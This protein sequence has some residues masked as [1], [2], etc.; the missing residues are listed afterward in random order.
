M[1]IKEL[2]SSDI[3]LRAKKHMDL[4][5]SN[6]KLQDAL[7]NFQRF[8]DENHEKSPDPI[9][10][11]PT[12]SEDIEVEK[13]LMVKKSRNAEVARWQGVE[14]FVLILCPFISGICN[15]IN[16][17]LMVNLLIQKNATK[18]DVSFFSLFLLSAG[19]FLQCGAITRGGGL[20]WFMLGMTILK[21]KNL[22]A[23][24]RSKDD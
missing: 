17:I 20:W 15:I 24:L 2:S 12:N 13:S 1:G 9:L 18:E 5:S 11:Q 10:S 23:A 21:V 14:L 22:I 6:K 8:V 4:N 3:I 7:N 19:T 16:G